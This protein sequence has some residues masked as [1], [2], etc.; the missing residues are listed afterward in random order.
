[1]PAS[2]LGPGAVPSAVSSARPW[3]ARMSA[4]ASARAGSLMRRGGRRCPHLSRRTAQRR[5]VIVRDRLRK[6][7]MTLREAD[8]TA[9]PR[10]A[11]NP[12]PPAGCHRRV[13]VAEFEPDPVQPQAQQFGGQLGH[14]RVG[15]GADVGARCARRRAVAA[16]RR[17]GRPAMGPVVGDARHAL[18]H[19]PVTVAHRAGLRVAPPNRSARRRARSI[20]AA[21]CSRT[22]PLRVVLGVIAQAQFDRIDAG[23]RRPARPSPTRA[24][25]CP[26]LRPARACRSASGMFSRASSWVTRRSGQA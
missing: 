16:D 3:R 21:T 4:L 2:A 26:R 19:Q 18:A 10:A 1:M 9:L 8:R 22:A 15:A 25:K 7:W 17:P 13:R 23:R 6:A 14:H 11:V 20:R 5:A 12:E 24:R